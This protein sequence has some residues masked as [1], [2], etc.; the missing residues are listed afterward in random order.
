M[1][2]QIDMIIISHLSQMPIIVYAKSSLNKHVEGMWQ[3]STNF[4]ESSNPP[5]SI[6]FDPPHYMIITK[7]NAAWEL[8]AKI[9]EQSFVDNQE[10]HEESSKGN[11]NSKLLVTPNSNDMDSV[12][13]NVN[14]K[15]VALSSVVFDNSIKEYARRYPKER[16]KKVTRKQTNFAT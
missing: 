3:G 16:G 11:K 7:G 4:K 12:D 10:T 9:N 5:A 8:S 14:D 15:H 6:F 13:E 1:G 2:E